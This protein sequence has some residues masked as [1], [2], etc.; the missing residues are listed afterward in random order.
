MEK[1]KKI[2]WVNLTMQIFY[3][4]LGTL[5]H[6]FIFPKFKQVFDEFRIKFHSIARFMI[7][8]HFVII[9]VCCNF[10]LFLWAW[11]HDCLDNRLIRLLINLIPLIIICVFFYSL[12]TPV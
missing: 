7:E 3:L 1:T 12:Y 11:K 10:A 8:T 2:F 4:L 9:F 5:S 6:V